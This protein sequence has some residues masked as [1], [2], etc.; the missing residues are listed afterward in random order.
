M[1][2]T[3]QVRAPLPA[4]RGSAAWCAAA[5]LVLAPAGAAGQELPSTPLS[6]QAPLP[7]PPPSTVPATG[8]QEQRAFLK[9]R[10]LVG[11]NVTHGL[12][13]D[14]D[15][16]SRWS[17]SPFFRNTPRRVGWGPS[18]GLNWF[19]GDL[20]FSIDGVRTTIGTVK[21]RPV[22]AG[23]G[24]TIGG[25]RTRTTLSLV[26][27]YAFTD[28]TVTA[29]LPPGTTATISIDDAWVVRPNIGMTVALTRRLALVGSIGYIYTN[30]TVTVNVT[31]TGGSA[32]QLSG[33]Y[34]SDYVNI[35]VGTA[36]SIF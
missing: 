21:V 28:A 25:S 7:A 20:A 30:P 4:P 3:S 33:T 6:W 36:V 8:R 2:Q 12:T 29:A 34:R 13:P 15:V 24:Y 9:G 17:L 31:R 27:G 1:A 19:T 10:F 11:A 35:T 32:T 18:F 26:G 5:W 23:V 16:G 22:M 14:D